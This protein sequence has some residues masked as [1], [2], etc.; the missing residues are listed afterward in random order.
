M[1]R[2]KRWVGVLESDNNA[3]PAAFGRSKSQ[4]RFSSE[5]GPYTSIKSMR[6]AMNVS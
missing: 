1:M 6:S 2:R 3:H 5:G 4:P